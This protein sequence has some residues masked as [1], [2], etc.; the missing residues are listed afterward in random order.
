MLAVSDAIARADWGDTPKPV[1][2]LHGQPDDEQHPT[3]LWD[4][5]W[6]VTW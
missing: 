5:E 1:I 6:E 2:A 4:G 3:L